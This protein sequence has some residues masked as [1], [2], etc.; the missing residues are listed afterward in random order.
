MRKPQRRS[1]RVQPC[2]DGEKEPSCPLS[3]K[4]WLSP[5]W[6]G[7]GRPTRVIRVFCNTPIH[8]QSAI[9]YIIPLFAIRSRNFSRSQGGRR[10]LLLPLLFPVCFSF[11]VFLAYLSPLLSPFLLREQAASLLPTDV[12]PTPCLAS[13]TTSPHGHLLLFEHDLDRGTQR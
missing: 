1:N 6:G 13:L 9:D 11:F 7:G 5:I 12:V 2:F 3:P 10:L 8:T 4:K